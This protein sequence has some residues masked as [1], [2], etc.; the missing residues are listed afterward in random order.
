MPAAKSESSRLAAGFLKG[1]LLDF[2]TYSALLA[3]ERDAAFRKILKELAATENRH[4]DIWAKVAGI[5]RHSRHVSRLHVL[6]MLL[7][8]RLMGL[9]FTVKLLELN[10]VR[11]ARQYSNALAGIKGNTLLKSQV[12]A[13][14]KDE[15]GHER[16]LQNMIEAQETELQYIKSI[17][18][19][20]NDGLVE[21]VAI[22]VGLA[23]VAKS[24]AIVAL[25]GTIAGISGTLSMSGGAYLSAKADKLVNARYG[26][27]TTPAR[28]AYFTGIY[29]ML[30]RKPTI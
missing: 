10:E 29:K 11:G 6:L 23:V 3:G 24:G 22:V 19:G 16:M 27:S 13:V 14:L 7:V 15:L 26:S 12:K 9:A 5:D 25:A 1:E 30:S 20:L 21:I 2:A 28:E 8:R 18:F 17:I 4:A